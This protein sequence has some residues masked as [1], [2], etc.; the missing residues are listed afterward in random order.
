MFPAVAPDPSNMGD[1]KLYPNSPLNEQGAGYG[2]PPSVLNMTVPT[3][4]T[5]GPQAPHS[6]QNKGDVPLHYY[7]IEFKRVDG[8]GFKLRWQEWYPW[9]KNMKYMR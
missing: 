7:R 5:M 8:E 6:I 9:M 2:P 3:C 1:T 4:T